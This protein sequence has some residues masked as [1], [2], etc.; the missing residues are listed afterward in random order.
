MSNQKLIF[1]LAAYAAIAISANFTIDKVE[2]RYAVWVLMG[3]LALKTLVASQQLRAQHA[4]EAAE[5]SRTD[6]VNSHEQQDGQGQ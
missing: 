5:R 4:A 6:E 1:A 2:F 3:G